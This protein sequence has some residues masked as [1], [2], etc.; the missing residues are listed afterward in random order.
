MSLVVIYN[1]SKIEIYSFIGALAA[2]IVLL[3]LV[4]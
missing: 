2:L 3:V 4:G 1:M